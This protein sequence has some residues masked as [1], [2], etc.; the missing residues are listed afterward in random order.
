MTE[1][2]D[3]IWVNI[4][5]RLAWILYLSAQG[6]T[7]EDA[8]F[9]FFVRTDPYGRTL[10]K[11]YDRLEHLG[12]DMNE[13]YRIGF[14]QHHLDLLRMRPKTRPPSLLGHQVD[15]AKL[16]DLYTA[17]LLRRS[18]CELQLAATLQKAEPKQ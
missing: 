2:A 13:L 11:H 18:Y 9:E 15:K 3:E 17:D 5:R 12:Y 7:K 14:S 1:S 10:Q 6:T 8:I 4:T 16:Q